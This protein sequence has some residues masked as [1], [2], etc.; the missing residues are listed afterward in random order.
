MEERRTDKSIKN[1]IYALVGQFFGI[2]ISLISRLVFVKILSSEYLGLSSLFTNIL[3]ILSLTEM[4]F[5]TAMAFELY[6]PIAKND[7]EKIKSL[8]KLYKKIYIIIGISIIILGIITIPVYPN[9]INER[10]NI[11]NLDLIYMLFVLNTAFSYFVAY[12]RLLIISDQNRYIATAYRYGFYIAMNV[13]QIIELVLFKNYI[14]YLIIQVLFTLLENIGISIKANKMYPYLKDKE[15]KEVAKRDKKHLMQN[16]K[17]LFFHRFGGVV[18]NSTDNIVISKVLGL[19][20]VGLY[21]NYYLITNA[22]NTILNQVFSSVVASIGNLNTSNTREKMTDTF[23]KIFFANVWIYAVVCSAF[24][25]LINPFIEIWLGRDYI[26]SFGTV[27]VLVVNYFVYGMRRPAM[28]F[29][30]ATGNYRKD[31]YSPIIEAVINIFVSIVMAKYIGLAG[32]F[33]GTIISSLCTNFWLE[34][35]VICKKSLKINL[36]QYFLMYLKY[37]LVVLIIVIVTYIVTALITIG[38]LC[39]LIIRGIISVVIPI[40]ILILIYFKNEYFKYYIAMFKR[41]ILKK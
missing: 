39:G 14:L 2:G 5:G 25:V 7:K 11:E 40:L 15:V 30:E 27:I 41:K 26:I 20:W 34:P 24:L 32:V 1:I 9:L 22:L 12:K 8:M 21:S 17:A 37:A 10:P 16:V 29:R 19:N 35:F 23:N 36:K 33:I 31:W 28:A 4:G 38:G 3:T 6:K 13:M 18:L